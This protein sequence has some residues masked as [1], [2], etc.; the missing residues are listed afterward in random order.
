MQVVP[1]V[2]VYPGEMGERAI[3]ARGHAQVQVTG[4]T[5]HQRAWQPMVF[6]HSGERRLEVVLGLGDEGCRR[7][8]PR[9]ASTRT[10]VPML[11][12]APDG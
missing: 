2:G 1:V 5:Q 11:V 6:Q 8:G 10:F 7:G 9:S 4:A 12:R 3:E